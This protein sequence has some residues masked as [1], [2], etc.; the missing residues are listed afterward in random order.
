MGRILPL[1]IFGLI[2]NL[3]TSSAIIVLTEKTDYIVG[4][5]IWLHVYTAGNATVQLV[6]NGSIIWEKSL[7]ESTL[8]SIPTSQLMEGEYTIYACDDR[9]E[10][11][12]SLRLESLKV[13]ATLE[14]KSRIEGNLVICGKT[15]LLDGYKLILEVDNLRK[16]VKVSNSSFCGIFD[17]DE[18]FYRVRVSFENETLK[19]S[20]IRVERFKIHSVRY[21]PE[22][23]VGE[24][25]KIGVSANVAG[26]D[27]KVVIYS[28]K[29]ERRIEKPILSDSGEVV[30]NA[31]LPPA[32]YNVMI[33]VIHENSTDMV[34]LPL[35]IRETFLSASVESVTDGK[36][37]VLAKAPIDHIIWIV[38][39]SR[40]EK[41]VVGE[42]RSLTLS[43]DLEG[44]VIV[45]DQLNHTDE[46]IKEMLE[47]GKIEV[48]YVKLK[49]NLSETESIRGDVSIE[50]L[51]SEYNFDLFAAL[52]TVL[53]V[54][55]TLIA[56]VFI[57]RG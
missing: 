39:G 37:T 44:D 47:S 5:T 29:T 2:V 6:R 15:N 45:L 8:V 32:D 50:N 25:L 54:G 51:G 27:L 53:I 4:E 26:F 36:A 28:N 34:K 9:S 10:V 40:I 23:Y 16:E 12:K 35:K 49:M 38:S 46:R 13:F 19:E 14:V 17:V 31:W 41:A 11:V 52:F 42:E 56:L 55:G 18:G 22:L 21:Q 30:L 43:I 48:P 7:N 24:P 1:L 20:E 57:I 3:G 33:L